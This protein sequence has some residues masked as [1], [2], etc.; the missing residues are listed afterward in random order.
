[1]TPAECDWSRIAFAASDAPAARS[2][3]LA[4]EKRHGRHDLQD[5]DVLV[6]LGGDGRMLRSLHDILARLRQDPNARNIPVYGMNCGS[7]GFLMNAYRENDLL[8]RLE[9]SVEARIHPLGV[10]LHLADGSRADALAINEV[11]LL[12][13]SH[14]AAKIR[15]RID[16]KT[17]LEELICDGV[18]LST[19]AGSTAY[20]L[21]VQ[22]PIL[23]MDAPLLALTPISA[24]RPRRWR[25]ALLPKRVRVCIDVLEARQRPVQA[26]A[27]Y[28]EFFHIE[29]IE[30]G[31][32]EGDG[33][34]L[35]FDSEHSWEER[36]LREQFQF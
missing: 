32:I 12:R 13:S 14:Q 30:A 2:A 6:V 18:L 11:S 19:P 7:V 28:Q 20:N 4:L 17:R 27:D 29:R 8:Q 15:I 33:L 35:L 1:M 34:R 36:I 31:S 21:S 25:G 3:L 5:A 24:F 16:A 26:A 9:K 22:G 23:P 10:E